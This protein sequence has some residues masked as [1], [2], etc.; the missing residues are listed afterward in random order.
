[1]DVIAVQVISAL[2]AASALPPTV[3]AGRQGNQG[4]LP[5]QRSA[6]GPEIADVGLLSWPALAAAALSEPVAPGAKVRSNASD[7]GAWAPQVQLSANTQFMDHLY[8]AKLLI[9]Q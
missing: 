8:P 5:Q 7:L 9:F 3:A 4:V 6:I 2:A 1:M